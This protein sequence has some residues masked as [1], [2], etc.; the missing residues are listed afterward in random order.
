MDS[1]ETLSYINDLKKL[2]KTNPNWQKVETYLLQHGGN[3]SLVDQIFDGLFERIVYTVGS[4]LIMFSQYAENHHLPTEKLIEIVIK[5]T[6][7]SKIKKI[8]VF[9]V[10][11]I[12]LQYYDILTQKID[13]N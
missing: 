9:T 1:D 6:P 3:R 8:T 11:S 13:S 5:T 12:L 10:N 7:I 4:Q 2:V